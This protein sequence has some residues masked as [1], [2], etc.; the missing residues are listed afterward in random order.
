MLD[1]TGPNKLKAV[2]YARLR[3]R[4]EPPLMHDYADV[5]G[6]LHIKPGKRVQLMTARGTAFFA[7]VNHERQC[8]KTGLT[9]ICLPWDVW[10]YPHDWGFTRTLL[11]NAYI[12]Q[13]CRA[14][15][16]WAAIF[17]G[18]PPGNGNGGPPGRG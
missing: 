2:P 18:I 9:P 7:H 13:M 10:I 14:L 1:P 4:V 16:Q 8:L 3:K 11:G 6:I 17:L 15:D 5:A 12:A